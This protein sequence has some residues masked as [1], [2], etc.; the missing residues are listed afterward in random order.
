MQFHSPIKCSHTFCTNTPPHYR[1]NIE[2]VALSIEVLGV[3]VG[4]GG[5]GSV[6]MVGT[7]PQKNH[8]CVTILENTHYL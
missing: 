2:A 1:E 7:L 4:W 6:F 5:A 8:Q 3:E